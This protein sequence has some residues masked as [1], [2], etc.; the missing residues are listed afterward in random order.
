MVLQRYNEV[1][2]MPDNYVPAIFNNGA[3]SHY[4]ITG[5]SLSG[6]ITSMHSFDGETLVIKDVNHQGYLEGELKLEDPENYTLLD[7]E[8]PESL[9][10]RITLKFLDL[11]ELFV[12]VRNKPGRII[13]FNTQLSVI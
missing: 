3:D 9:S 12:S 2:E 7:S 13:C 1:S 6:L 11:E 10:S 4:Q 8:E 5:E